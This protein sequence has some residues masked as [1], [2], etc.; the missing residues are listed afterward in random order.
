MADPRTFSSLCHSVK[1][2]YGSTDDVAPA[3]Y[4]GRGN[5]IFVPLVATDELP[6]GIELAGA[7]RQLNECDLDRLRNQ[8]SEFLGEIMSSG[9]IFWLSNRSGQVDKVCHK[10]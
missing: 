10:R 8:N 5:G 3:W 7:P 9:K 1:P 2:A 4:V 6:P